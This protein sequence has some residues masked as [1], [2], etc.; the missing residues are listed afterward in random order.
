MGKLRSAT[1]IRFRHIEDLSYLWLQQASNLG[2][3]NGVHDTICYYGNNVFKV[4]EV[5]QH[6]IDHEARQLRFDTPGQYA[7]ETL[8]KKPMDSTWK[9][10]FL[11]SSLLTD[12]CEL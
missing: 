4:N 7:G 2:W 11:P 9:K 1:F 10:P 6:I 3:M 8:R 5:L 12:I